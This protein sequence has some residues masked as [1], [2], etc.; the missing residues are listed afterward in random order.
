[1]SYMPSCVTKLSCADLGVEDEPP[2]AAWPSGSVWKSRRRL[3]FAGSACGAANGILSGSDSIGETM[4][5]EGVRTLQNQDPFVCMFSL[6][7]PPPHASASLSSSTHTRK[8]SSF[9]FCIACHDE[10]SDGC[11][12]MSS[13]GSNPGMPS[14]VLLLIKH[15]PC[16]ASF[17]CGGVQGPFGVPRGA[18]APV[19]A[20]PSSHVRRAGSPQDSGSSSPHAASGI[21][22]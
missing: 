9:R 5:V 4:T 15:V 10:P 2:H 21:L 19:V 13:T 22:V 17:G 16:C 1:M 18:T 11:A 3:L 20:P 7:S 6:S 8:S 12:G 14:A